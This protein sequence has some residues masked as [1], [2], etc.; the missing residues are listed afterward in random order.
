MIPVEKLT[1]ILKEP[2]KDVLRH[3]CLVENSLAWVDERL[4]DEKLLD[5]CGSVRLV[6]GHLRLEILAEEIDELRHELVGNLITEHVDELDTGGLE[7]HQVVNGHVLL[8][9]KFR[10]DELV[11]VLLEQLRGDANFSGS[12]LVCVAADA[13]SDDQVDHCRHLLPV[14]LLVLRVICMHLSNQRTD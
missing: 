3:V 4:F 10:H 1:E 14:C 7:N 13:R 12:M 8:N 6:Y 2:S 11:D 9:L 5:A